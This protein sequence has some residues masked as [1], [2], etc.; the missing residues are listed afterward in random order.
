MKTEQLIAKK[1][2]HHFNSKEKQVLFD[3]IS[4]NDNYD[5]LL[6]HD[7]DII[8]FEEGELV[9]G[10]VKAGDVNMDNAVSKEVVEDSEETGMSFEEAEKLLNTCH[11]IALPEWQ[12]FWFKNRQTDELLVLTKE[13]QIVNTPFDEFKERNDWKVVNPTEEQAELLE[14]YWEE[15]E[16]SLKENT[17]TTEPVI[18]VKVTA[19]TLQDNPE[20]IEEGIIVG[21]IITV[22][23]VETIEEITVGLE[24][25]EVI[26]EEV[27]APVKT[28]KKKTAKKQ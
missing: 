20:L 6:I 11:L 3:V 26:S 23:A 4:L 2:K 24:E 12:G 16:N 14:D 15:F 1:V 27:I 13:G 18:E 19:E 21:E 9:N 7:S 17:K 10:Y 22:D 8:Y 5:G 25:I 28:T